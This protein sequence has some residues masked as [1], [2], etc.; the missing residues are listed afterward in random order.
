[1]VRQE[2]LTGQKVTILID[3]GATYNYIQTNSNIGETIPLPKIY[4]TKTLHGYSQVKAKKIINIFDHNLTFLE[5]NELMDFDMILGEIKS[6]KG[7]YK[8]L[9]L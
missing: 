9:Q 1:M 7:Y 4:I 6:D 8:F 3:S 5:I 2:R